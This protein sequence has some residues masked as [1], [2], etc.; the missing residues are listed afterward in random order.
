MLYNKYAMS[1]VG[2]WDSKASRASLDNYVAVFIDGRYI[3]SA[4]TVHETVESC[5]AD[6]IVSC[7]DARSEIA[8][9]M[10]CGIVIVCEHSQ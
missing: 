10:R 1:D 9:A 6:H 8:I 3:V 2:I 7:C 4:I 5:K